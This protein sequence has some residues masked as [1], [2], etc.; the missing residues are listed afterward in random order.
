MS[1]NIETLPNGTGWFV[2]D[3]IVE[4][5]GLVLSKEG[6][7]VKYKTIPS[8]IFETRERLLNNERY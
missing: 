1:I 7:R 8:Y 5:S 4:F 2:D 6:K 3:Y